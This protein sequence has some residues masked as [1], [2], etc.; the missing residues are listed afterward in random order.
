MFES[1]RGGRV[2]VTQKKNPKGAWTLKDFG[3]KIRLQ[4][5]LGLDEIAPLEAPPNFQT[6]TAKITTYFLDV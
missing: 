2:F 5:A 1:P 6:Q 3:P 4:Q